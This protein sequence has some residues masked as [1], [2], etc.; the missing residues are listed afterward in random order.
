MVRFVY[1]T[2]SLK[3]KNF[4][5]N[6]QLLWEY[7]GSVLC[8]DLI[9]NIVDACLDDISTSVA[10]GVHAISIDAFVVSSTN[11]K[12]GVPPTEQFC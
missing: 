6:Q 3:P 9:F 8:G 1:F 10:S 5:R 4:C 11:V 2:S 7:V 12:Y